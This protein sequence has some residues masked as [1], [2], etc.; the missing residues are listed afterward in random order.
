MLVH[1]LI[2][3]TTAAAVKLLSGEYSDDPLTVHTIFETIFQ[4]VFAILDI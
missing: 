4:P 3:G 1:N 2:D